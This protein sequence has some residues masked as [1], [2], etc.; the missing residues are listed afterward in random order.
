MRCLVVFF[1]ILLQSAGSW[2]LSEIKLAHIQRPGALDGFVSRHHVAHSVCKDLSCGR[3]LLL[4]KL[5]TNSSE[6]QLLVSVED[7]LFFIF[8]GLTFLIC[9][10]DTMGLQMQW[11][12]SNFSSIACVRDLVLGH[13]YGRSTLHFGRK[14]HKLFRVL[15]S[16]TWY[17]CRIFHTPT[18]FMTETS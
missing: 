13:R 11:T 1:A 6:F 12:D 7:I 18:W 15:Q 8:W 14:T 9:E 3:I 17:L 2:Y 4:F 16:L 10:S 5:L